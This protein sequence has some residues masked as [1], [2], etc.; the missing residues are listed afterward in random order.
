MF[1]DDENPWEEEDDITNEAVARFEDMLANHRPVYFDAEEFELI[2]DFYMQHDDLKRSRE[3]VDLA[4]AQHPDDINLRIKNARQYLVENKPETALK[5]L[6]QTEI[7]TE[8]PDYYLT[9]G[10]CYAALGY[11]QAAIRTYIKALSYFDEDERGELYHAIGSEYQKNLNFTEAIDYFRKSLESASDPMLFQSTFAELTNCF[12]NS[13]QIQEGI[14][15]YNQRIEKNPYEAESWS[16]LGDIY[17]RAAQLEQAIDM[18][19]YVLAIDPTHL[20]ANMNLANA[21]YDLNRFQEA[22]DSLNEALEHHLE[23]SMIHASLGDCHYRLGHFIDAVNEYNKALKLN[24]YLTEAWS[25]LG[26]VYSDTGDSKKA[27]R[28]FEKAHELE[29]FNED[30]LYNLAAEYRKVGENAKALDFLLQIEKNQPND[31][32]LYFFLGDLLAELGRS[33]EAINYLHLGLQ[34]TEGDASLLYLL[35]FIYLER[36]DRK[37][38][39]RYLD[40]ALDADPSYYK[41]YIEYDP[42]L[43]GKDVEI[44]ELIHRRIRGI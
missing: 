13:G 3:A 15:Y 9:L 20:W 10:S 28:Y 1:T 11:S 25:G 41:E 42:E 12:V 36:N 37:M 30:N 29:P 22:I 2:I 18:Y 24:E 31:P 44:M 16:A 23:T 39:F 40:E 8:E 6:D 4:I 32:D 27:I 5:L 19:E 38:A 26:Y 33:E 21:Y 34:R 17:R 7:N 43:I 35:S 14:E